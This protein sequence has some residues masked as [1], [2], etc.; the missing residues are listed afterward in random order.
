MLIIFL[1]GCVRLS[2]PGP[3][4]PALPG[5]T[6]QNSQVDPRAP[7]V[8]GSLPEV[9]ISQIQGAQHRSP[10][11]GQDVTCVQGIVTAVDGGGFFMQSLWA[12]EDERTSEGLYVELRAYALVSQGDHVVVLSGDIKEYNPA[13]VGA[14]SLTLTSLRTSEVE[15]LSRGNQL[16]EPVVMGRGGRPIPGRVIENDIQGYVNKAVTGFDP[17]ED[18]MDFFESL[19]SMLVQVNDALAVSTINSYNEVTV[20]ADGGKDADLL[21]EF[22]VLVLRH[23]DFNPERIMLD[24]KFIHM[25]DILTGARFS[26]P[27][28]G[29]M[30]YDFGNYRLQP[31]EKLVFTQ[32][33]LPVQSYTGIRGHTQLAVATYNVENLD[34]QADP[35][36]LVD[37]ADDIVFD[38][39]AP[40]ILV[41]QEVMDDDGVLDSEVTSADKTLEALS[42][43]VRNL[44]GPRYA[45]LN[46]DP[47]RGA[48]GGSP[49]GNIRVVIFYRTDRGLIPLDKPIGG[50]RQENGVTLVNGRAE[51]TLNP[52]R[53]WPGNSAFVNSRRPIAAQFEF[54]GQPLIIIG[55][56]FNSKGED[57]PLYG[58][59]QPPVL[60]SER[61]RI[62]QAKAVNGF[63]KDI[64]EIDPQAKIIV[65]GDLNDF[66]WS[67]PV[68]TLAG[69]QLSNLFDTL[70]QSQRFNYLY[71]GN[72]QVLD[73]ILISRSLESRLVTVD[74]LH[75]NSIQHP[76]Y[77]LS[78]HDPVV[79]VFEFGN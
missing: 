24:D 6:S 56:H 62:A 45:W 75:L 47:E 65:L 23:D 5:E 19:E 7:G 22:G 2:L 34:A 37:L 27:I 72:A 11:D 29:I 42:K 41:I 64:L 40:D 66:P 14:N 8:C 74:V 76:D 21:S 39:A 36:R 55:N 16:P 71:E 77:A 61:Q 25:P 28:R 78:D 59:I 69:N 49:G 67:E 48:D 68:R 44:G 58:N 70:P 33:T 12:D 30:M 54:N 43:A 73:Q 35:A 10:F 1:A 52:G 18:G 3:V 51:L 53:I 15:V 38:L 32:G 60:K 9:T 13:G 31:V 46:I 26:Q 20:V 4:E 50:A 79:S 17:D 57:D 63:V